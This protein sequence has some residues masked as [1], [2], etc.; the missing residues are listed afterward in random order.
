MTAFAAAAAVA[1]AAT[2]TLSALAADT[3]GTPVGGGGGATCGQWSTREC[4]GVVGKTRQLTFL[5]VIDR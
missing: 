2:D 5:L 3:T 1:I 4:V